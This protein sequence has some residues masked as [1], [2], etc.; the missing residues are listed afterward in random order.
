MF[1]VIVVYVAGVIVINGASGVSFVNGASGVS[2]AAFSG[3]ASSI[4]A[5]GRWAFSHGAVESCNVAFSSS[6]CKGEFAVVGVGVD[7][8]IVVHG[9][10]GVSFSGIRNISSYGWVCG[11]K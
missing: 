9:A 7:C 5:S 6:W 8:V 4:G 10:S 1:A 11:F 2:F 3:R